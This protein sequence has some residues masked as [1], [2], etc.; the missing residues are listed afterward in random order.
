MS[1]TDQPTRQPRSLTPQGKIRFQTRRDF[2]AAQ[3]LIRRSDLG[4]KEPGVVAL[5][6]IVN[7]DAT[8]PITCKHRWQD[9]AYEWH[10]CD[11]PA[12]V[13]IVRNRGYEYDENFEPT[14]TPAS[15]YS[16][17]FCVD[18]VRQAFCRWADQQV[19]QIADGVHAKRAGSD[20]REHGDAG[21][22]E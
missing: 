10:S 14:D 4:Y 12:D 1:D 16:D 21:G 13:R 19:D 22:E 11:A 20:A 6:P 7:A 8:D 3:E 17:A 15:V 18:C 9:D 2:E 5:E